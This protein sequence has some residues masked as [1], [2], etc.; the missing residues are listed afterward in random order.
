MLRNVIN[1]LIIGIALGVAKHV[2]KQVPFQDWHWWVA[3]L[4]ILITIE[5]NYFFGKENK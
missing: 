3:F 2:D 5:V 1:G 4:L